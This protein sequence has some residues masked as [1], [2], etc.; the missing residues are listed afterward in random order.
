VSAG[1]SRT[2]RWLWLAGWIAVLVAAAWFVWLAIL[3]Q[4]VRALQENETFANRTFWYLAHIAIAVPVL[5]IA[6]MQFVAGVRGAR[7]E[8]HR[9]LGRTYLSLSIV[10]GT[11]GAYL[12][13]TMQ[14]S[15][16]R[17]PLTLAACLWVAFSVAAWA[18]ARHR[19]FAV[20]RAFVIRGLAF[21]LV[22]VWTRAMQV[23]EDQLFFFV[24]AG[25][26]RGATREWVAFVLPLLVA[27]TWLT[28]WP[29]IAKT[30]NH[31]PAGRHQPA[32]P[33]GHP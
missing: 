22:F 15:G 6:P 10:G 19:A 7:P 14:N 30:K 32:P 27:E 12:G 18:A 11:L 1:R 26:M 17:L 9:I 4:G 3:F 2:R 16:S 21:A 13:A 28:W 20:H 5:A 24:E 23:V 31:A 25:E 33:P 29:T 8:V